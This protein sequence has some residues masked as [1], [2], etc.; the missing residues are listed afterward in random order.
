[1][2]LLGPAVSVENVKREACELPVKSTAETGYEVD[3]IDSQRSN[4][5]VA[6]FLCPH[7]ALASSSEARQDADELPF[8]QQEITLNDTESSIVQHDSTTV[9]S[10]KVQLN[11]VSVCPETK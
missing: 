7:P 2:L 11:R 1:M 5:S 3:Q 6:V 9:I 8:Y 4:S 10:S